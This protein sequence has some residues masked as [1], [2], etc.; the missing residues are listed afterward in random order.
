MSEMAAFF[1]LPKQELTWWIWGIPDRKRY[2]RF[3]IQKRNGDVRNIDA[4]IQPIKL[5]QRKLATALAGAFDGPLHAHGFV[6]GRSTVTGARY[7]Q[8]Q[9]W[10]ANVDL[11]DFFPSITFGRVRGLFMS[12][13]FNYPTAVATA[14]AQLCCHKGSLPQ[15]AP[16]SPAISN[17]ICRAMDAQ[18]ASLARRERCYYT[19]YAD[20]MTIST[21]RSVPPI[22]IAETV[23]GE[24]LVGDAVRAIIESN[25]FRVNDDKTRIS[26]FARR[27]LVTGIVVNRKLN[28]TREY[29]RNLRRVLYIWEKFDEASAQRRAQIDVKSNNWPPNKPEPNFKS[30]IEGR[31]LRIGEVKGWDDPVYLDLVAR[32]ERIDP[33]LSMKRE[34]LDDPDRA[35]P[36]AVRLFVEGKTDRIILEAALEYFHGQ[37][38]Y[39]DLQF[40]FD[41][42]SVRNGDTGV[43]EFCDHLSVS[44]Q[45]ICCIGVVDRDGKIGT[46]IGAMTD[47]IE[48]LPKGVAKIALVPPDFRPN[49][50]Q[51]CIEMLFPDDVLH[52]QNVDGRR[53]F[54]REEF[55]R[56]STLHTSGKF[57][58]PNVNH[59]SLV[60]DPVYKAVGGTP[61]SVAL[62]K[63]EFA[64]GVAAGNPP[65]GGIDFDG[66]RPTFDSI[67][68][69]V[70]KATPR[71]STQSVGA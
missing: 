15:G 58:V 30:V 9:Q 56:V 41:A 53:I 7:H 23:N 50:S 69:A 33:K 62:S 1:E 44:Q 13:P 45:P 25:G 46:A 22:S 59:Q 66:F 27:Q 51:V 19:R 39:L 17:L 29:A 31:I 68:K 2:T 55:N 11:T 47:S 28:V 6:L 64:A 42:E 35:K 37:G 10:V 57:A 18:L 3:Q 34:V 43:N 8:R 61:V 21:N 4:P 26:R 32:I 36:R 65:Y 48:M 71:L 60:A 63:V 49:S 20:D 5:L 14:L 24:F 40:Q 12:S 70:D 67:R 54:L 38:E 52:R 16:T